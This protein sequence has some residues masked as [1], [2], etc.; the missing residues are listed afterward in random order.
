[1][2]TIIGLIFGPMIFIGWLVIYNFTHQKEIKNELQSSQKGVPYSKK[3]ASN[4]SPKERRWALMTA[5]VVL[6]L[7]TICAYMLFTGHQIAA[8]TVLACLPILIP[9]IVKLGDTMTKE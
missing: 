7:V 6:I 5:V 1:M 3:L 9:V 8:A 2:P 4:Y